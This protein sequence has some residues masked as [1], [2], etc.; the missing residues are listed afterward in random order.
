MDFDS[1]SKGGRRQPGN[2]RNK[3]GSLER[4]PGFPSRFCAMFS[5]VH[6]ASAFSVQG[7]LLPS[8]EDWCVSKNDRRCCKEPSESNVR[9]PQIRGL[10]ASENSAK[11]SQDF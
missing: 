8:P 7:K 10:V 2:T 9:L 6:L 5:K 3:C 4:L 11:E 1:C